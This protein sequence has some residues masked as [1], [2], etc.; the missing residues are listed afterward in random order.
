MSG[1]LFAPSITLRS[2]WSF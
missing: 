2:L 1:D